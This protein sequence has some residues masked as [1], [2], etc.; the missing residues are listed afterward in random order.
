M[1]QCPQLGQILP[2][3]FEHVHHTLFLPNFDRE[4]C[5][6]IAWCLTLTLTFILI[7]GY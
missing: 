5:D 7:L 3:F 4:Q 2:M 6:D 1:C